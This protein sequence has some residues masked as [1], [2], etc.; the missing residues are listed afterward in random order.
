MI[1]TFS[2]DY[3]EEYTSPIIGKGLTGSKSEST[4][5]NLIG[6]TI[7]YAED[8]ANNNHITLIKEFRCSDG[9]PGLIGDQ[10]VMIGTSLRSVSTIT[11][12]INQVCSN[13]N[14]ND[15]DND[16]EDDDIDEDR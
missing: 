2:Y 6:S 12:Y 8:W 5:P 16:N 11:I 3:N 10:S 14:N 1:K 13:G 15:N 4:V 7:K 9:V